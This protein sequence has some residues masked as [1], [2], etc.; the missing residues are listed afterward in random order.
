MASLKRRLEGRGTDTAEAVQKRLN[1]AIEEIRYAQTGAHDTVIVN[2]DNLIDEAYEKFKN[3]A[4]GNETDL[5]TLP[6]LTLD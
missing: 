2:G 3:V 6:D 4:L 1:T 5:D